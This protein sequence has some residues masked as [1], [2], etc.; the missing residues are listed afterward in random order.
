VQ[1]IAAPSA[2]ATWVGFAGAAAIAVTLIGITGAGTTFT[3]DEWGILFRLADRPLADAVFDP[4]A[5][6]YL[7]VLPTLVYAALSELFGTDSYLPYRVVGMVLVVLAA[8]LYLEFA[9]RR[10]GHALALGGA[11]VLMFFGAASDVVAI[12]GR[13]PSQIAMCAGL[14]MFLGL[15]RQDPRGDVVA[16][17]LCA[18]AVTSH[19]VGLAFLAAGFVRVALDEPARRWARSWVVLIPLALYGLW[20][21]TLYDPIETPRPSFAEAV[22][23]GWEGFVAV[24]GALAG[25]FRTPW[26]VDVDFLNAW[27]TLLAIGFLALGAVAVARTRRVTPGLLAVVVA[28]GIDLIAPA[29][30]PGLNVFRQPIAPRYLYPGAIFV[31]LVAA[32][33]VRARPLDSR[34][35]PLAVIACVLVFASAMYSN[36]AY[37]VDRTDSLTAAADTTRAGLGAL[38]LA[39]EDE[40][41]LAA[42][43]SPEESVQVMSFLGSPIAPGPDEL[44][45]VGPAYFAI[46]DEFGSPA[47][48]RTELERAAPDLKQHADVVLATAL[49]VELEPERRGTPR[50][51]S[52]S[53][54]RLD[55]DAELPPGRVTIESVDRGRP[56]LALGRLAIQPAYRLRWP[57]GA[58]AASLRLPTAGLGELAW[59]LRAAAGSGATAC[60]LGRR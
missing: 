31:L 6:K 4:P 29:I 3:G 50:P 42:T 26:T 20:Y 2:T 19:P 21:V 10:T 28:L 12:P 17:L 32:E 47:S 46:T 52:R 43:V 15:D 33:V 41:G 1:R 25:V 35:R 48:T 37:M 23:F 7:L 30:G 54:A 45:R 18:V 51:A 27:S 13:I 24:C 11:I 49:A 22:S 34:F 58:R 36:V 39:R 14:G 8:V 56:E 5:G 38:E 59:R 57:S 55:P 60:S 16:C 53:C 40:G 44:P 9:R